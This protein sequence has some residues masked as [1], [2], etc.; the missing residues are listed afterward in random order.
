MENISIFSVSSIPGKHVI[1]ISFLYSRSPELFKVFSLSHE[2]LWLS[3]DISEI[4]PRHTERQIDPIKLVL[5]ASCLLSFSVH[6]KLLSLG[7]RHLLSLC[8]C[9]Y[10]HALFLQYVVCILCTVSTSSV[11]TIIPKWL[12]LPNCTVRIV[13]KMQCTQLDLRFP[14]ILCII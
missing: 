14:G 3:A 13:Q 6:L 12:L 4:R 9:S 10:Q 2:T 5:Y 8:F 11:C 7:E 1:M